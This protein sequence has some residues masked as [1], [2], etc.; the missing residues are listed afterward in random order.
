MIKNQKGFTVIEILI[1]TVIVAVLT[2]AIVYVYEIYV[3]QAYA[4]E[5]IPM[6]K[7]IQDAQ[8]NYYAEHGKWAESILQI[9]GKKEYNFYPLT[10]NTG[11]RGNG[12]GISTK[13][14]VY[15]TYV[16]EERKEKTGELTYKPYIHV[17]RHTRR[18]SNGIL[19]YL[20]HYGVSLYNIEYSKMHYRS[21]RFTA[22]RVKNYVF[23]RILKS[24]I[25][26]WH[27]HMDDIV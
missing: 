27:S 20:Y 24:L 17:Y 7:A 10:S 1:T 6:V 3:E 13:Y 18:F 26:N 23:K 25:G 5:I 9:E 19:D 21:A 12:H 2:T 8:H 11:F 16:F 14:F 4:S 15:G 22:G